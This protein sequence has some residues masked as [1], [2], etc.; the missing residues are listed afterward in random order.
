MVKANI[1]DKDKKQL[2][3]ELVNANMTISDN[4]EVANHFN[5][6]FISVADEICAEIPQIPFNFPNYPVENEG[7]D[8][9]N[10]T[11]ENKVLNIIN[12]LKNTTSTDIDGIP[13]AILNTCK[14]N[15]APVLTKIINQFMREGVF[16]DSLMMSKIIPIFKGGDTDH[17]KN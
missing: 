9:L 3:L 17:V 16:P 12:D 10:D 5:S 15:I 2:K 14:K 13:T 4:F 6:Y 11:T 7:D 1:V 8:I